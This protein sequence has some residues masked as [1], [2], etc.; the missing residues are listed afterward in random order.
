MSEIAT[1]F[2]N[3]VFPENIIFVQFLGILLAMIETRS[4]RSSY[5]KGVKY[6][7]SIFTS[8]L[9]GWI[10]M[11]WIPE[12]YEFILIWLFL[13]I[14]LFVV[15]LLQKWGELKGEW[16]GFPK[17]ILILVP[18]IG[19]QWNLLEQGMDY[20]HKIFMI[21]GNVAGFYLAFMLIATI[22]EQIKISESPAVLKKVPTILIAIGFFT[23]AFIG[24][25]FI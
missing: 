15:Y 23:L 21:A 19:L 6:A 8:G 25:S 17:F 3:N 22:K 9:L 2:W 5:K 11:A 24:F 18:M 16:N 12:S 20:V 4:I 7:V 1:I 13:I 14:A 10:F